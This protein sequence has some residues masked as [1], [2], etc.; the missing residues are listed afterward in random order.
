MDMISSL[1]LAW[2][3]YCVLL[4]SVKPIERRDIEPENV[5]DV[6]SFLVDLLSDKLRRVAC[7]VV[8]GVFS[9]VARPRQLI[10]IVAIIVSFVERVHI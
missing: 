1:N 8:E 6:Q 4:T 10:A 7:G 9:S 2:L 3:V 5:V